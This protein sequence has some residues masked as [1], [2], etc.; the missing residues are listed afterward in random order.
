MTAVGVPGLWENGSQR[1]RRTVAG[2]TAS[3]HPS[4][5]QNGQGL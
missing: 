2:P 1:D 4:L 5:L 3:H